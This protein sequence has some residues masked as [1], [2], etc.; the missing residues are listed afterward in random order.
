MSR[1]YETL[2]IN[3]I[4]KKSNNNNATATT[5]SINKFAKVALTQEQAKCVK[6]GIVITEELE[7]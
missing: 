4:M 1:P 5:T 7:A 2:K 6:G 3:V